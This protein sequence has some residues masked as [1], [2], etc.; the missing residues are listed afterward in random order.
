MQGKDVH[1]SRAVSF[2]FDPQGLPARS[3]ATVFACASDS[4]GPLEQAHRR[5]A[6][7]DA[8]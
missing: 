2:I 8:D 7:H 1:S 4:A 3:M 6:S 5:V